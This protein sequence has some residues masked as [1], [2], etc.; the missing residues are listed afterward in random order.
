MIDKTVI[1]PIDDRRLG[2][3]DE[4]LHFDRRGMGPFVI[5]L[6]VRA[7]ISPNLNYPD[8]RISLGQ[9]VGSEPTGD[10]PDFGGVLLTIQDVDEL[11]VVLKAARAAVVKACPSLAH[12]TVVED[13][14]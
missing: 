3:V 2:T 7:N 13:L 12:V 8:A 6:Q 9:S 14:S 11:I 1:G 4:V 5:A 10:A